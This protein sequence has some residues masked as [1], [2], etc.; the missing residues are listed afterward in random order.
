MNRFVVAEEIEKIFSR[1]TRVPSVVMWN[2]LEG[3]PRRSDYTRA[4]KAEVRDPLWLITRQW[5]MGEFIGEDAGSPVTAKV[6]WKTDSVSAIHS[7]AGE[8]EPYDPN[9]PLETVIEARPI[10]L[11]RAGRFHNI[12]LRLALAGVGSSC[13]K[14][15][16]FAVT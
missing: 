9:V 10:Q 13:L 7:P 1:E 2:R 4:L 15:M 5:Q 12:D 6:A 3:R 11:D 8:V 16:D 14:T